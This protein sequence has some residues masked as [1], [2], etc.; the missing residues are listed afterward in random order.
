MARRQENGIREYCCCPVENDIIQMLFQDDGTDTLVPVTARP[1]ERSLLL[2][3]FPHPVSTALH[4][5]MNQL[6]PATGPNPASTISVWSAELASYP[7]ISLR[8][9]IGAGG[10][11]ID[12][13]RAGVFFL[14]QLGA[15]AIGIASSMLFFRRVF[16]TGFWLDCIGGLVDSLVLTAAL[17]FAFRSVRNGAVAALVTAAVMTLV[18]LPVYWGIAVEH[19]RLA[20]PNMT[21]NFAAVPFLFSIFTHIFLLVFALHLAVSNIRT[22]WIAVGIG[23]I[24]GRLV[25]GLTSQ[26]MVTAY[27]AMQRERSPFG[28]VHFLFNQA[29]GITAGSLLTGTAFSLLFVGG[30]ECLGGLAALPGVRLAPGVPVGA[31]SDAIGRLRAA[32]GYRTVI[33]SLRPA[34][35][36][37]IV[38]GLVAIGLGISSMSGNPVN[39]LLACLGFVLFGEGIWLVAA[40]TPAGMVVDGFALIV[41]GIWNLFVTVLNA[42]SGGS[43]S[44]G[45]AVM[46]IWQV[47][48]GFQSFGRYLRFRKTSL[49][50]PSPESMAQIDQVVQELRK[51]PAGAEGI[52]EFEAK[53]GPH[54]RWKARLLPDLAVFVC[55]KE[56]EIVI[57]A[58]AE[59]KITIAE[60]VRAR[61]LNLPVVI[62]LG[63][64]RLDGS[65]SPEA[66]ERFRRWQ[67]APAT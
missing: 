58:R 4:R 60:A 23:A 5:I 8:A 27:Y 24:A 61:S 56:A 19:N 13:R 49:S 41:L 22:L 15:W 1:E 32:A 64:R 51:L 30:F 52:I 42:S 21:W 40:P 38:F 25:A 66:L 34:G 17:V 3:H 26:S 12:C 29:L 55:G 20:G 31:G 59:T 6:S 44:G 14:A 45:F 33:R 57:T 62:D 43:S 37:S 16:P 39:A 35:I 65:I 50:P 10:G 53:G 7:E 2:A 67:V 9:L 28:D 46:G 48:W 63:G 47:V 54:K 11:Q 36:G 18:M